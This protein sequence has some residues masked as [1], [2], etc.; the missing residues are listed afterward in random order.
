MNFDEKHFRE[1][2]QIAE[3]CLHHQKELD[4]PHTLSGEGGGGGGW[5]MFSLSICNTGTMYMNFDKKHFR[6]SDQIAE[7]RLHHQKELDFPH[8]LSRGGEGGGG[9]VTSYIWHSTDVRA[10][11]PP[12]SALPGI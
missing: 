6:D 10:E 9:G 8:T 1:S 5:R 12:F 3:Q 2:D 4:F 11:W 7:Q